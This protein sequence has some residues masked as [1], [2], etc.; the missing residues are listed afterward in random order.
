MLCIALLYFQ[1]PWYGPRVFLI[2]F[3][4][5]EHVD[6]KKKLWKLGRTSLPKKIVKALPPFRQ[7]E[8]QGKYFHHLFMA[9]IIQE[10]KRFPHLDSIGSWHSSYVCILVFI[11]Q[12][13]AKFNISHISLHVYSF[14]SFFFAKAKIYLIYVFEVMSYKY[15]KCWNRIN[16]SILS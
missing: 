2:Q 16:C 12:W 3:S 9:L 13:N 11:N 15:F 8:N 1:L 5:R 6:Y 7:V 4:C 10:T 14:F